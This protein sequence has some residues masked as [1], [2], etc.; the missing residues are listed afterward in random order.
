VEKN[1]KISIHVIGVVI[2]MNK[3]RDNKEACEK[4]KKPL[5]RFE[6]CKFLHIGNCRYCH[7]EYHDEEYI[8]L[9]LENIDDWIARS[10]TARDHREISMGY[11]AKI[12]WFIKYQADEFQIIIEL[13]ETMIATDVEV[14]NTRGE[15]LGLQKYW[16]WVRNYNID[17]V[18][19]KTILWRIYE[20]ECRREDLKNQAMALHHLRKFVLVEGENSEDEII[21]Y[22]TLSSSIESEINNNNFVEYVG[23][24]V[25]FLFNCTFDARAELDSIVE[26]A[27]SKIENDFIRDLYMACFCSR[28]LN[29]SEHLGKGIFSLSV[30]TENSEVLFQENITLLM[31]SPDAEPNMPIFDDSLM[32]FDLANIVNLLS[33]KYQ[34]FSN[35]FEKFIDFLDEQADK[36]TVYLVSTHGIICEY[37]DFINRIVFDSRY[38]IIIPLLSNNLS[39]DIS[40]VTI[41]R[42]SSDSII[43]T[44]DR[45]RSEQENHPKW[46]D[47]NIVKSLRRFKVTKEGFRLR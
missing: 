18:D 20:T 39:Q 38:N 9:I 42:S 19:Q 10:I 40:F 44:E 8:P 31:I 30:P 35:P 1:G 15:A 2:Q 13:F 34:R 26:V 46:V 37:P 23:S 4:C 25:S 43:I 21:H 7:P 14:E 41:A 17:L 3:L 28:R 32:V 24:L 16:K 33:R 36:N 5:C 22:L 45:L 12:D 11:D 47:E 29:R 27:I 6:E